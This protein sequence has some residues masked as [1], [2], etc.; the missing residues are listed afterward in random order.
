MVRVSRLQKFSSPLVWAVAGHILVKM[1]HH[2]MEVFIL[3]DPLP[4]E[5]IGIKLAT[6]FNVR[7]DDGPKG[8]FL[9][10]RNYASA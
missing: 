3:I 9:A 1:V 6:A 10:I 7:A 5:V 2:L 8:V 4:A